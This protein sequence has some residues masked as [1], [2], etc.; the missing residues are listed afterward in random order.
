VAKNTLLSK[1]CSLPI[2]VNMKEENQALA[3]VSSRI[4]HLVV[5]DVLATGVARHRKPLL[6]DHLKELQKSQRALRDINS[7]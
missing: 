6:K 5:I 7:N 4:A 1:Q 3:P 2:Y